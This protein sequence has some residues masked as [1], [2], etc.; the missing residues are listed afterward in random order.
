M[1]M[2]SPTSHKREEVANT[3]ASEEV[4]AVH[5]PV[6]CCPC[7]HAAG[8]GKWFCVLFAFSHGAHQ[9][10][11]FF[12]DQSSSSSRLRRLHLSERP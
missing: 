8:D 6:V 1:S 4:P 12:R 2:R 7:M 5:V 11:V 9:T 10:G 3:G